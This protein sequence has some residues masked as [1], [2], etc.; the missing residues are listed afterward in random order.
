[1]SRIEEY[2]QFVEAKQYR[3][4]ECGFDI[5]PD[6]LN[7]H[8]KPF[9]RAVT[10][11]AL[12]RGRAAIFED[13]GLGKTIQLLEW[14][15]QVCTH[16]GG[17]VLILS[18]LCVAP[19]TVS[20][21]RK[22]GIGGVEYRRDGSSGDSRIVVTNYEMMGHFNPADFVGVVADESS[23]IKNETG[24]TRQAILD[25]FRDT[26]Y[27]LSCTATP[28]PNDFM[29]LGNQ[30]E[31][32][33]VMSFTEM[34]SMF[35]VHDGGETSKWRLKGHGRER[36]WEW[37]S[38]WSVVIK[39]PSDIGFDDEGYDLPPLNV[40]EHIVQS[41]ASIP[42]G[43]LFALPAASLNDTRR[44]QRESIDQRTDECAMLVNNSPGQ[45]VVWCHLND[46][47]D[48]LVKKI[49][50]AMD[51]K[52]SYSVDVKEQRIADFTSGKLRVL[53]SK[54][55]ITGWGL[56]WQHCNKMAFVGLS[57]SWESY[58][59]A[60]RRCWRFGQ[61]H[62]VDVHLIRADTDGAVKSA[63]QRKEQQADEMS[64]AMVEHMS[65]IMKRKIR[66]AKIGEYHMLT[67]TAEGDGWKM[68]LG[69]CVEVMSEMESDSIHYSI[70]SPPFASLYT[71]S[72]SPNDM[73]NTKSHGE[74]YDQFKFC[75]E[76]L[77]RVLK[78]GRLVSFHCMNMQTLK[79]RDGFIGLTDFRG[80][81][82]RMF[83]DAGFIYHSEVTIWKDPVTAMQ[84][85]KALG[86]LWKQ[87]KKDSSMC[88][89][90][91]PDYLVTMRKPGDNDEPV[92]HTAEE[93][94]VALWQRYASPV[95]MDINQ[96]DTLN[97]AEAREDEDE[98]HICPL[99][100]GVIRRALKIW[101]NPGDTVLTPFA[102]I[103]SEVYV[104]LQE[105]R[106]GIGIE[107]KPKYFDVAKRN[108]SSAIAQMGLFDAI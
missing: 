101:T 13:T 36:F 53:V 65:D 97:R 11:W 75:V 104:A 16:T 30:A 23:I 73:G 72:N 71:Y 74:F 14:A 38:T 44:A 50:G 55:S 105:G 17:R 91:I 54:P 6:M 42:D 49:S 2:R 34:L 61:E 7:H 15:N 47:S 94:P 21:A 52:G 67:D 99:Q 19:Q 4:V 41:E 45:W 90:G 107:L 29:E 87:I 27:R 60:V 58:Y 80:E 5:D 93:F 33:G 79:Q 18:P 77:Y 59:Q 10:R 70:F 1:M 24:K 76:Q 108:C 48:A 106:R 102:G 43:Q 28:S 22:F 88:R 86:L 92:S 83:S 95:W 32:L 89:Q 46:E 39:R 31:F 3:D 63:L 51:V 26:P 12:A 8:L 85:T 57:Y 82:I 40:H 98:R 20:E 64:T 78:P 68:Y 84:R 81:L 37:M 9:Q 66:G 56:N 25:A 100:L 62:E 96:S 35:F 103:G 69:D